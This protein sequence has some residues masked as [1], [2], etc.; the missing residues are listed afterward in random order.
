LIRSLATLPLLVLAAASL[1]PCA[2]CS[3]SPESG[4]ASAPPVAQSAWS[5]SAEPA[6]AVSVVD[7]QKAAPKEDVVVVGRVRLLV[8]GLAA[9]TMVDTSVAYCGDPQASKD[10]KKQMEEICEQPW[11][12]C[13]NEQEAAEKQ[14]AVVVPGPG[15]SAAKGAIPELRNLDLVVVKGR[16][17]KDKAGNVELA[18]VGWYRKERPAI[19]ASVKFPQ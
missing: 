14:I 11:D 12:Y 2:A 18:A 1:L 8:T 6:G 10:G 15:G 4:G 5:L 9:F 7:A 16:L 17:V 3:K 13:C 19:P